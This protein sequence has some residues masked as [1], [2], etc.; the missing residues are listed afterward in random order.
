MATDLRSGARIATWDAPGLV[1]S[2]AWDPDTRRLLAGM[3][4]DGNI[5]AWDLTEFLKGNG[6]RAPP[7]STPGIDTGMTGVL[8]MV[9]PLDESVI[10]VRSADQVKIFERTTGAEMANRDI[11]VD[12]VTYTTAVS[13]DSPVTARV[14]AL[15]MARQTIMSLD[16]S[17][18][19][20]TSTQRPESAPLGTLLTTGHGSNQLVWVPVGPLPADDE[21]PAT[22][23][24]MLDPQGRHDHPRRHGPAPRPGA[25]HGLGLGRQPRLRGRA[26]AGV[27]HRAPR[28]QPLRLRGLRR[29]PGGRHAGP[30][31]VRHQRHLPDR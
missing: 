17:S 6:E 27:G 9:L 15:D 31:G 4:D 16:A 30:D 28:G 18:L 22:D 24:G 20:T 5:A 14:I 2:L 13:G 19:E 3:T 23:G 10:V 7:V 21:H 1:A 25:V 11:A 8:Q 26:V 12:A 29:D